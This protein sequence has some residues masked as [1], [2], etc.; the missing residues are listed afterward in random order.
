MTLERLARLVQ[1]GF[2]QGRG[3]N[4]K[5][6]IRI[7][8]RMSSPV[9]NVSAVLVPTHHRSI[10][11]L[12]TIEYGAANLAAW[13]GATEIRSQFPLFP[14]PAPHP[15]SKGVD[16][17]APSRDLAPGLLAIAAAAGID[18]GRYPGTDVPYVATC[19]LV[20]TMGGEGEERLVFW[21]CKSRSAL[22]AGGKKERRAYERLELERRYAKAISAHSYVY[23][24]DE[25]PAVMLA[26]LDWLAPRRHHYASEKWTV[27]RARFA[28]AYADSGAELSIARRIGLASER[29]RIEPKDGHRLFQWSAW[30]G[31][32]PLDICRPIL[33]HRPMP[34]LDPTYRRRLQGKLMGVQ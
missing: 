21:S 18:H 16:A 19:D 13:L 28:E 32:V 4:Y 20:I 15:L 33:L 3:E 26:N 1:Q 24:E 11:A 7:T 25:V 10:S 6:W 29:L 22:H 8:R 17:N 12:S 5:E 34:V 23:L 14:W 30:T 2:G 31:E 9:S 27:E